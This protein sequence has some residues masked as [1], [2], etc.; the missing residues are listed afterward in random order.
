[1]TSEFQIRKEMVEVGRRMYEKGLVAATDGNISFRTSNNEILITPSGTCLGFLKSSELVLIDREGRVLSGRLKPTSEY[2]LHLEVY[3]QRD[4]VRAVVHA[5][6][7]LCTAFSVAGVTLEQCVLP[8]VVF[9]L[10]A[11][12]TTGY[13]TPTTDE[14]PRV[15]REYIGQCDAMILDRHGTLTVGEDLVG[16]YLK[17]EKL[18]H[19]AKTLIAAKMLGRVQ[20]LSEEQVESLMKVRKEMGEKGPIIRCVHC[21]N[22]NNRPTDPKT[23]EDRLAQTISSEVLKLING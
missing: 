7:P 16:T 9:T 4:D 18:E 23:D 5:H 21:T 13:A 3:R 19:T 15:V 10:G 14:P 1:M 6:P 8:E 12:P 22:L 20:V 2:R 17:L 11:I